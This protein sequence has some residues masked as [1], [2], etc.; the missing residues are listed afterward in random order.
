MFGNIKTSDHWLYLSGLSFFMS[1]KGV[2]FFCSRC[3]SPPFFF[4][5][6]HFQ[7]AKPPEDFLETCLC[8]F[9]S[10]WLC[11]LALKDELTRRAHGIPEKIKTPKSLL[12][13]PITASWR[14]LDIYIFSGISVSLVYPE[15]LKSSWFSFFF[16]PFF[17]GLGGEVGTVVWIS[18]S[19]SFIIRWTR[20]TASGHIFSL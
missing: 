4:S 20:A 7:L 10:P 8:S 17:V 19:S 9:S 15:L 13:W 18:F 5:G 1:L 6:R 12:S 2:D 11:P 14:T 16:F 3:V